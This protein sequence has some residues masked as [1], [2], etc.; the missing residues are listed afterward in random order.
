[1]KRKTTSKKQNVSWIEEIPK[2]SIALRKFGQEKAIL[3]GKSAWF[4]P[5]KFPVEPGALVGII[6][7]NVSIFLKNIIKYH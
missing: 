6:E 7:V 2:S 5:Q 1:M 4:P 3:H